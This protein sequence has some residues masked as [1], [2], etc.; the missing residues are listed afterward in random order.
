MTDLSRKLS[1]ISRSEN[2]F[3]FEEERCLKIFNEFSNQ[4]ISNKSF[5][6]ILISIYCMTVVVSS[7]LITFFPTQ[8]QLPQYYCL[9]DYEYF[10]LL[11]NYI[12]DGH[13][14]DL[15]SEI[16]RNENKNK[17]Y[18]N[19]INAFDWK[20]SNFQKIKFFNNEKCIKKYCSDKDGNLK[21][22]LNLF[23]TSKNS[24]QRFNLESF[25]NH[26]A[27]VV[28]PKIGIRKFTNNYFFAK[29]KFEFFH[30]EAL[31]Q[32][33][34]NTPKV[35][36]GNNGEKLKDSNS[37]GKFIK[38]VVVDYET[39]TNFVTVYDAFCDYE[40]FF[41]NT[42]L[43][44]NI[45]RIIGGLVMSYISDTYGRNFIFKYL[46]FSMFITHL[47]PI[48]FGSRFFIYLFMFLSSMN[49][50]IYFLIL[51]MSSE[52][53]SQKYYSLAMSIIIAI[54]S[55]TGVFI[56]LIDYIFKNLFIIFYIT[57][58]FIFAVYYFQR[59]YFVETFAFCFSKRRYKQAYDS[60]EYL[61]ILLGLNF[62][63]NKNKAKEM[64]QLKT[65][66]YGFSSR[67]NSHI[68]DSKVGRLHNDTEPNKRLGELI[69]Q[70]NI[71]QNSGLNKKNL[72]TH[73]FQILELDKNKTNNLYRK[74]QDMMYKILGPYRLI[75][76]KKKYFMDFLLFLPHYITIN[77][78]YF[79]QI[80][81]VEKIN[82]N[83][84]ITSMI[85]FISELIGEF[86]SGYLAPKYGRKT[87]FYILYASLA[88]L[89][90]SMFIIKNKFLILI[91][92]FISSSLLAAIYCILYIFSGETF[93]VKI[94]SCMGILLINSYLIVL[95]LFQYFIA[96]INNLFFLF[97]IMICLSLLFT[98][99]LK[100]TFK[101]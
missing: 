79:M 51:F 23:D 26:N 41:A 3:S 16:I 59:K 35:Y 62:Y 49:N 36:R 5:Q 53:L 54:F 100:E 60:L 98:K 40:E 84:Y 18:N 19:I 50:N 71:Q 77:V 81:N 61:N 39:I 55:L 22:S 33:E 2:N 90:F 42:I 66:A 89:Y 64:N 14:H 76:V 45:G 94:K 93:D 12:Y 74:C 82:D 97:F 25:D 11:G 83:I 27:K 67:K 20:I 99:C 88:V 101:V 87:L 48:I 78:S 65:F 46:I 58:I 28:L 96:F 13:V 21:N 32:Y 15:D 52:T 34:L 63:E 43:C 1:E 68:L 9:D 38:V 6:I 69:I 37:E 75:F 31:N 24:R 10:S 80:F 56:I 91:L 44:L 17:I 7:V 86:L 29:L 72:N 30:L 95:I 8:K 47:L 85:L 92:L 57:I 4:I 73:D 70:D